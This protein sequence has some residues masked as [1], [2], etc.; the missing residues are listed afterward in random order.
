MHKASLLVALVLVAGCTSPA[1]VKEITIPG[2]GSQV[3]VFTHDIR[4]A[5][6][7]P[8]NDETGIRSLFT[9]ADAITIVFDGSSSTDNGYFQVVSI[10]VIDKLRT[11]FAYE[12]KVMRFS[13]AYYLGDTWYDADGEIEKP[14][15]T[16]ALWLM[17]PDT[18]AAET[19]LTLDGSIVY[20]RGTSYKN[21]TLAGDKLALVVMNVRI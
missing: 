19:S 14:N 3:Y 15:L 21:L 20:L 8:A 17:G 16:D 10:N 12:G 13:P 9:Q 4:E 2:H 1:P 18:G 5:S 7:V 11:Y 6:K